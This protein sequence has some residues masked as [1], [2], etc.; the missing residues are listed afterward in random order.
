MEAL[1]MHTSNALERLATQLGHSAACG[2]ERLL[3]R[4]AQEDRRGCGE[5]HAQDRGRSH[6]RCGLLLAQ[7]LCGDLP[8]REVASPEETSWLQAQTRRGCVEAAGSG[9]RRACYGHPATE[10]RVL[11]ASLRGG[12]Q[13]LHDL[14][15]PQAP[16]MDRKEIGE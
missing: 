16:R 2:D 14:Q 13:R 1:P 12:G 15:G 3:R 5:G 8:R 7:A 9:S 6:L 4:P 11:V 10:A